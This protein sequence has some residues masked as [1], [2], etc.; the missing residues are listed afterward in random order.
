MSHTCQK[1][2]E[3]NNHE[4][5][6]LGGDGGG[7]DGITSGTS[8]PN[9]IAPRDKIEVR[10]MPNGIFHPWVRWDSGVEVARKF[11]RRRRRRRPPKVGVW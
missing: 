4:P 5:P 7:D 11:F 2:K 1:A 8:T 6:T 9:P 3:N 10:G